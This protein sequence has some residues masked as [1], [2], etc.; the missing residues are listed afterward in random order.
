MSKYMIKRVLSA[1][2][3][4]LVVFSLNFVIINTTP[5]SPIKTMMG[6][7][8]DNI[9]LQKAL[10]KKYGFDQPLYKQYFKYLENVSKGDL[11]VSVIYNR[12]VKDM[13]LEKMGPTVLLVLSSAIISLILGTAMG[14]SAARRERSLLDVIFSSVNYILNSMPSFWLGLMLVIIFSTKLNLLPTFGM[15]DPRA[16][17]TGIDYFV[18]VL[19]H[20][21][22]PVLTM[23]LIQMPLYFRI[24]KS[25]V[26]QVV[27]EDYIQTFRACGM[28]EEKVFNKYIFKNAILPTI[29]I[30]GIS[31]AYLVTGVA[32][33]EIIFAWPGTGRLVLNAIN[34]RDYPTLMGIYLVMSISIAVVMMLVDIIYAFVDPRIRYG[35]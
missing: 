9:E 13:I 34:Q 17:Y 24:A 11:G 1:L 12:P 8:V 35:D 4:V 19:K 18:D 5:G 3:T 23:V 16:D 22:L 2:L 32:L 21:V 31:I 25:S 20:L 28:S 10:E 26:L 33:V 29:T 7:E 30:F 15:T 27:N 14:I 6:K